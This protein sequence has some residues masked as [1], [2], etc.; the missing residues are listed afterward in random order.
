M[1]FQRKRRLQ[2]RQIQ[3]LHMILDGL[4]V[5]HE[6]YSNLAED[7]EGRSENVKSQAAAMA[8]CTAHWAEEVQK[9]IDGELHY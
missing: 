7:Y 1:K 3:G 9:A 2:S 4:K 8:R 5:Q 6:I